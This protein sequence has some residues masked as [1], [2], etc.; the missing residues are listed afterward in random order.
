[1]NNK[2]LHT[3]QTHKWCLC[4][5]INAWVLYCAMR[6]LRHELST[7]NYKGH[8]TIITTAKKHPLLQNVQPR[9]SNQ[10]DIGN[11]LKCVCLSCPVQ[12]AFWWV[13]HT[14]HSF[15]RH[16]FQISTAPEGNDLH[17]SHPAPSKTLFSELLPLFFMSVT[18]FFALTHC[19]CFSYCSTSDKRAPFLQCVYYYMCRGIVCCSVHCWDVMPLGQVIIVVENWFSTDLSG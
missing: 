18:F 15:G 10:Q 7:E 8:F 14:G 16:S 9:E 4:Y 1:M 19:E 12:P 17:P 5:Y 3:E 6:M 13:Y 11:G 2:D